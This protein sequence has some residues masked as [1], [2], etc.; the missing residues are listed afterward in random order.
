MNKVVEQIHREFNN[1]G[2]VLLKEAQEVL[3]LQSSDKAKR[4]ESVGFKLAKGV[5]E[6]KEQDERR[7]EAEKL[8]ALINDYAMR[9]P[10]NRFITDTQVER[11][12]KK[13]N[14]VCGPVASYKG[15]VPE[16]NLHQIEEFRSRGYPH[17]ADIHEK[18]IKIHLESMSS[19]KMVKEKYPDLVVPESKI[20]WGVPQVTDVERSWFDRYERIDNQS[21]RICAPAKDM[22]LSGLKKVGKQWFSLTRVEVPDPVVLQPVK[23]GYLIVTA[24]GD[25]A[26]DEDVVNPKMN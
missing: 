3:K 7:Q 8:F 24:W 18:T 14:L 6:G 23:G 11:I 5:K 19:K 25:E 17:F 26:S 22:E 16:K 15:F 2:D 12:C 1:A 20:Y 21:Q 4:L 13:Y 9:Y 10:N